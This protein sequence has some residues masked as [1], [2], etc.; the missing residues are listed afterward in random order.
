MQL[1]LFK[2]PLKRQP[3]RRYQDIDYIGLREVP[4]VHH[5]K[6]LVSDNDV[7]ILGGNQGLD[8]YR[9]RQDRAWVI[10]DCK[11]FADY[12][13]DVIECTYNHSVQ[14]TPEG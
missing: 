13:W 14:V 8:Y 1:G 11:P 7:V 12:M 9:F 3:V 2:M 5:Y 6:A 10:R 4:G